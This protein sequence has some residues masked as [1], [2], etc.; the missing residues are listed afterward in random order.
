MSTTITKA[1]TLVETLAER[2]APWSVTELAGRLGLPKSNIH[3]LLAALS[4]KG[5]VEQDPA[6][7][8]Y[9]LTLRLWELGTRV[10]GRMDLR[11][12]ASPFL[13][14][15]AETTAETVNLAILDHGEV[16]YLHKIDS[17]MPV[18][19]YTPEGRRAPA[20]C[21]STG[22]AMLAYQPEDAIRKVALQIRQHTGRTVG[23][24]R[25]LRRELQHVREAG[26]SMNCGEWRDSVRGVAAPIRDSTGTVVAAVGVF[27]PA[28]RLP[29]R[30]L[31]RMAAA[32]RNA[33]AAI[34]GALGYT[35]P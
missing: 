19:A 3:F 5:Y 24:L 18:R 23:G 25:E 22:K 6:T 30:K 13:A 33:A 21:T 20:Y 11:R 12:V 2:A 1:L 4:A 29:A 16:L 17:P 31:T 9:F 7:R 28:E 14:S 34:S 8:R 32:V 15:L 26:Y 35:P 10:L 27:G